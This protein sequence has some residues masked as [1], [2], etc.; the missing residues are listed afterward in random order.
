MVRGGLSLRADAVART[1]EDL[2]PRLSAMVSAAVPLP[3]GAEWLLDNHFV[4]RRALREVRRGFTRGFERALTRCSEPEKGLRA[5]ELAVRIFRALEH[6]VEVST[7]DRELRNLSLEPELKL[8]ELWAL[9]LLLR[10]VALE[11]VA[12]NADAVV[13]R[14]GGDSDR[15]VADS[16]R[17]LLV[18]QKAD[19]KS[20]VE[21]ASQVHQILGQDPSGD[22]PNM[23]FA[24]RDRYRKVIEELA[25]GL[26]TE[27]RTVAETAIRL[28]SPGPM[29]PASHVGRVI[30]GADR[31]ALEKELGYRPGVIESTGQLIRRFAIGCYLG[32]IVGVAVAHLGVLWWS[33]EG[34]G[35]A[36]W[37][38]VVTCAVAIAPAFTVGVSVVNWVTAL[39]L[40]PTPLPKLQ[41]RDGIPPEYRALVVIPALITSRSEVRSLL[42][43][44][45]SHRLA[46]P[47]PGL[48]FALLTDFGDADVELTPSDEALLAMAQDGIR[49]LNRAYGGAGDRPFGIFH[50]KRVWSPRQGRFMG[51]E[52]KRG[53]LEE[54]NRMLLGD[55]DTTYLTGDGY[56][57]VPT[58]VRYVITLDADTILPHGAARRLVE[59]LAHPLNCARFDEATGRV[60]EGYTVLQPRAELTPGSTA[61]WFARTYAGEGV[62]D[63]YTRAV[64]DVYQDL[65]GEGIFVGKGIYEVA[66][67]HRA[68]CGHI[69][70]DQVLSHDLLEGVLGRAGLATDVIV[71]EDYPRTYLSYARRL[72]RWVRGD[73]Q[74]LPWLGRRGRGLSVLARWKIVDNLRRSLL[75][76]SVVALL[77]LGWVWL[78]GSAW[79]WTG[80][81]ALLLAT[82]A[83]TD[84][85]GE[86]LRGVKP[87]ALRLA[88]VGTITATPGAL[89]RWALRSAFLPHEALLS[90]DAAARAVA[91]SAV[92]RRDQLEWTAAA[93]AGRGTGRALTVWREM[94][95]VSIASVGIGMILWVLGDEIWVGAAPFLVAWACSPV[96]A[97]WT[98]R[99]PK[100]GRPEVG[101]V[102][103]EQ[104]RRLA[105]RTWLYFETFVGPEDHWLP[106][107]N[108]QEHPDGKVAHRTSPTNVGMALLATLA[109]RDLGYV[110]LLELVVRIRSTLETLVG[111]ERHE[112]HLL[113]WYDTMTLEP[114]APRYVSTVD[115][116][117]LAAALV[118]IKQA[119]LTLASDA[120][121]LHHRFAGLTDTVGLVAN[122]LG[123]WPI[124]VEANP[125]LDVIRQMEDALKGAGPVPLESAS[126]LETLADLC[127]HLDRCL[128]QMLE[129]TA[130]SAATS[131]MTPLREWAMRLRG[132]VAAARRELDH[133]TP[134]V[135][136]MHRRPAAAN[137][138]HLASALEPVDRLLLQ[139]PRL[140]DASE[141]CGRAL[142][143]L[144]SPPMAVARRESTDGPKGPEGVKEWLDDLRSAL[145][146]TAET[147]SGI[148]TRL[149]AIADTADALVRGMSFSS[150]YDPDRRLFYI[151][152]DAT[153]ERFDEHHY[154]LLASEARVASFIAIAK[155]DV[156]EEHWS[157]L[158]RPIGRFGG[159]RGLLS[160]SGTMFE[161]LMPPL[162]LA[163]RPQ[164]LLG[165]TNRAAV[166]AQQ[167]YGEKRGVPWGISES[168]YAHVDAD[169]NYQYR[170][171][172][173]PTLGFKRGLARELVI[174]P[175]ATVLAVQLDPGAVSRNLATL[176]DLQA[177][178]TFGLHE[179]VDF[180][181][182]RTPL[183]ASHIV[184]RSYMSH[185][186][187]MILVA[188]GN[189]LSDRSMVDRF[190]QEPMVRAAEVL[191]HERSPGRVPVER[192]QAAAEGPDAG[193]PRP[194]AL[195]GWP[196]RNLGSGVDAHL[197]SNGRF[198]LIVTAAG[199][200]YSWWK[201]VAVTRRSEDPVFEDLG[202]W[203]YLEDVED[204]TRWSLNATSEE[205]E[206]RE[207]EFEAHL[208]RFRVQ[209]HGI[210]AEMVVFV[211]PDG[212]A[213]VRH[214]TLT[215]SGT[216][217]R[218]IRVTGY[219]ELV[220]GSASEDARH[221]AFSKLFVESEVQGD[222]GALVF[223]RRPRS[224]DD[225]SAWA[226]HRLVADGKVATRYQVDRERFLGRG[227]SLQDPAF[228]LR[229]V[230]AGTECA[231]TLD[232]VMVL[233][234]VMDVGPELGVEC[235]F[236]TVVAESRSEVLSLGTEFS[237]LGRLIR[238]REDAAMEA[239]RVCA[240]DGLSTADLVTQQR[241][242]SSVLYPARHNRAASDVVLRNRLGQSGLWRYAVSGD[243]PII[244]VRVRSN[245]Q[246]GV[247]KPL[248]RAH[249]FWRKRGVA[250]DLVIVNEEAASY[251]EAARE[252]LTWLTQLA[253]DHLGARGGGVF[254]V[255]GCLMEAGGLD[256]LLASARVIVDAAELSLESVIGFDG[257]SVAP[258]P[259][260]EPEGQVPLATAPLSRP[261]EIA[262]DAIGG[263][264]RD[265]TEYVVHLDP[266]THTPAPWVNVLANPTFGTVV[267]ESG[268]G[269]TWA[270][271]S[272]LN[273]ITEWTNDPVCDTPSESLYIRDELSGEIW[274]PTPEPAPA[275]SAYQV[276]HGFGYTVFH[277]HSHGLRQTTEI[278]V[279]HD[280]PVKVTRVK[281]ENGWPR[282]RRLTVTVH[283]EWVLGVSRSRDGAFV[284]PEFVAEDEVLLARNP[285]NE[286]LPG[287]YA[288]LAA[289]EPLHGL[290]ADR[291]EFL[292]RGG[293]RAVPD[294]L[295]RIGLSGRLPVGGDVCGTL[296][297]H[298]DLEPGRSIELH[299]LLGQGASR[300]A[301]IELVRKYRQPEAVVRASAAV[302]ERWRRVLGRVQV[303]TPDPH[304]DRM[305]NGWLLYQ[306]MSSRLWGR[307]GFYQSSGAF[308]FRDQLQDVMALVHLD[309][310]LT[311]AHILE[312]ARHQFVEG[313]VLHWWHPPSGKGIR[314]RCSDDLVWLPYVTAH[315][316]E[317][318]G[319]TDL[320]QERVP[321][322]SGPELAPE[323]QEQY[324]AGFAIEPPETL[325][326]HCV[327]ALERAVRL[328]GHGLPLMG[329]CDWNDGMSRVGERGQGESVWMGWFLGASLK[330]FAQVCETVG[331]SEDA[332]RFLQLVEQ[333][334]GPLEASWDGAWYRRAYDDD[335][336]PLGAADSEE[337][338]I[339]SIAQ[340]WAVLSEIA[341]APRAVRAMSSVWDRLVRPHD[342]LVLLFD[343]PFDRSSLEPGYIKGYPPGVRENGGQYTHAAVWVAWALAQVGQPERAHDVLRMVMPG[344]HHGADADRIQRYR[345]EPY[346]VAADIYSG[347]GLVGRGGWSWYTGAAAWAYR[348]GLEAL[349]GLRR[350]AGRLRLEPN[351]PAG[352]PGYSLQIRDQGSTYSIRVENRGTGRDVA[353]WVVDGRTHPPPVILPP[354]DGAGHQVLVRL[355]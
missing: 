353:D 112:G 289:S 12:A 134:W 26:A 230:P 343:P 33:L 166:R 320:L 313:D 141:M 249:R 240:G 58:S 115:S 143:A 256:L 84:L 291:K 330:Q 205:R 105:R 47:D 78:P 21:N 303:Q 57:P 290:T 41:F 346:V 168:G 259:R 189:F 127:I 281:L 294:G 238:A 326:E 100:R 254:L 336:H 255:H 277:H 119:C 211:A 146:T 269:Y 61:T 151:G 282:P 42:Q 94:G 165:R 272:G 280:N 4:V 236:V 35:V 253:G 276:R 101:E 147:A 162:V 109:A 302:R 161:Y 246:T 273:R 124:P 96:L 116:G 301:A 136:V 122:E 337:C 296:Q 263:F 327:R 329:S 351:I 64:S 247:I 14:A 209:R 5:Y 271:N 120:R 252:R 154:D 92:T 187:G 118:V 23:D 91:R 319:D 305:L 164:T 38:A 334:R 59:T 297:V 232:T 317:A 34:S 31:P 66:A 159:E 174:A 231:A 71:Y 17:S 321:F 11:A 312:A 345:I 241:L 25:L 335:G 77:V 98:A 340:S 108:Y 148:Q 210:A 258:L 314:S 220:L 350:Q 206:G 130:D 217:S 90:L 68:V 50:R 341:R 348:C 28:A 55:T 207:V 194:A 332:A 170:A 95:A 81:V 30:I 224:A 7:L 19:W 39:A 309:P 69:P 333:L 79:V 300:D 344:A 8:A 139:L 244:V 142:D 1:L 262:P 86:A 24:T 52:R 328:G 338:Q 214:L 2:Y 219:G 184:V 283:V 22:Y 156:P 62:F 186:Q 347:P 185:H 175:Y 72:H 221:P 349:L 10:L 183:G 53:K 323:E 278:F 199:A 76:P 51:W 208:T 45:E 293:Q 192:A 298:V 275:G 200:G 103:R 292:G 288:F 270:G 49:E 242:L 67:F 306:A 80:L 173:V 171:F 237:T 257:E 138:G 203:I 128:L 274:S 85:A 73:W 228:R 213:E 74:L 299:F 354:A 307:T 87:G 160:W 227:G 83:L 212:D 239:A 20:F 222:T 295:R 137:E 243:L 121:P 190:H 325:Y 179:A 223:H 202:F 286:D 167:R 158:G 229:P 107:D 155:G 117:N 248:L 250:V 15:I 89:A 36:P 176:S 188:L 287:H 3:P 140:A 169:D 63:I 233:Q 132:E 97:L 88:L 265:G 133:V 195:S 163:E 13:R 27:E 111:L 266:G 315:Y 106:P 216:S 177:W 235:A 352:W 60:V 322:I 251:A 197:V 18:L 32:P 48:E 75:A 316:V 114:L 135:A 342:G 264:S 218:R 129:R 152:Y 279:T 225:A 93:H 311:R 131:T 261:D 215:C 310:D 16:V 149:R 308:G 339:D 65:F 331:R 267:T 99:E 29:G 260:F 182:G 43:N 318:T 110:D 201:D 234:T 284:V 126:T 268:G 44:I 70:P 37:L 150:L 54:F 157:Y 181:R 144:A 355:K 113:N 191:L 123:S 198:G 104:L 193:G 196:A 324:H 145:E 304:L 6:R 172:G 125:A 9:P 226:G 178:G 285:W 82:P 153:A 56:D 46:N 40:R 245:K 180:T 204:G 102:D